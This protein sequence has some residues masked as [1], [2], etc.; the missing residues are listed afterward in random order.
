M[1]TD[2]LPLALYWASFNRFELRLPGAAVN[3]IAQSGSNDEAV[4]LWASKVC[5]E[6]PERA[7]PDAIRAELKEYGAW[8]ETELADDAENWERLLWIAAHNIVDS[9]TPADCSPSVGEAKRLRAGEAGGF[10]ILQWCARSKDRHWT[11]NLLRGEYLATFPTRREAREAL[12]QTRLYV[13]R[14]AGSLTPIHE[15]ARRHLATLPR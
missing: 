11:L 9:D 2:L 12:K 14:D 1:K 6:W 5:N 10:R 7:T 3:D 8:D 13:L 15:V 4:A